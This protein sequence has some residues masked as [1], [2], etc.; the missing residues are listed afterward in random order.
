MVI[1]I[2]LFSANSFITERYY[3]T[4][5]YPLAAIFFRSVTGWLPFSLGD[6]LYG[7]V[8]IWLLFKAAKGIKALL[9]QQ[10]TWQSLI[11]TFSKTLIVLLIIYVI[12][13]IFWGINY[14]RRGIASQLGLTMEKYSAQDLKI[15]NTILLQKVNASKTASLHRGPVILTSKEIFKEAAE[16]YSE[17]SKKYSFLEYNTKNIKISLW[18]WLGNYAG[19]TGYYN[20]FTGEAQVNTTIPKFSQ[21]Y[22]TC[23]EIGHQ[24]GYAKE[25]EANFVGYLAATASKDSSFLYSA[26]L[27]LFLYAD[28]NL[29]SVD[30]TA[31]KELAHQ[32]L[33]SVKADL[34]EMRNFNRRH[35]NPFE[36]VIRWMYGKYLQSNQQPSGVLSYDE[37]TGFLIAYYK[38]NG[39]L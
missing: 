38:K 23:H 15:V 14:N 20:P 37:V 19:F 34:K 31:A 2:R 25:D 26:Y 27:D 16:A 36:P 28:R 7:A 11:N 35:Q 13:N 3:S 22:T 9:K 32:L 8:V 39:S 5:F 17:V 24:I 6:L 21:P 12:F 1:L 29:Y 18:G 30:S 4:G 33:P 10:V